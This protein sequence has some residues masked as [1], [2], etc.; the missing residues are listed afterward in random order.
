MVGDIRVRWLDS[1]C[2]RTCAP[3]QP[4]QLQGN[5]SPHA[6]A[7]PP[8][9]TT[10]RRATLTRIGAPPIDMRE[11]LVLLPPSE[12]RPR[13]PIDMREF[14]FELETPPK[15]V[16]RAAMVAGPASGCVVRVGEAAGGGRRGEEEEGSWWHSQA[17]A[18]SAAVRQRRRHDVARRR[19]R[20]HC[21]TRPLRASVGGRSTVQPAAGQ[22]HRTSAC[23]AVSNG[24]PPPPPPVHR[25]EQPRQR[26]TAASSPTRRPPFLLARAAAATAAA[27]LS[28]LAPAAN[29]EG[30]APEGNDHRRARPR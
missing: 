18:A 22:L 30:V 3:H 24:P 27:E 25:R 7:H 29:V 11:R 6:H 14:R 16:R 20:Y 21:S 19:L 2:T 28:G 10:P 1:G 8:T 23:D 9:H 13:L 5:V 15:V 4:R 26:A 12:G 17:H